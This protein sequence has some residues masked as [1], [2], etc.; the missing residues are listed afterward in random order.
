M[1]K[2]T[3]EQNIATI[4]KN[5]PNNYNEEYKVGFTIQ[6]NTFF[7]KLVLKKILDNGVRVKPVDYSKALIVLSYFAGILEDDNKI[8]ENLV[9]AS[10]AL[11]AK[12]KEAGT[13]NRSHYLKL[14]AVVIEC[15][16]RGRE[17]NT[18]YQDKTTFDEVNKR[19]EKY[20]PKIDSKNDDF[21]KPDFYYEGIA[22]KIIDI[23]R[24]EYHSFLT[25]VS[26]RS[27]LSAVIFADA[28]FQT[29]PDDKEES[30][31]K[32]KFSNKDYLNASIEALNHLKKN[33]SVE[34]WYKELG[35][36]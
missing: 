11:K 30:L 9:R 24:D 25:S 10:K 7:Q 3:I 15:G 20:G 16:L 6:E 22:S 8:C 4:L 36:K 14:E 17:K 26:N 23:T 32:N 34:E 12:E 29:R 21:R 1:K 35:V 19:F 18:N 31:V 33:S 2:I 27:E 5:S 28:I 13:N